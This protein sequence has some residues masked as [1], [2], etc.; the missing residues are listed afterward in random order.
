VN[1]EVH[2]PFCKRL[3]VRFLR[4]THHSCHYILDWKFDEDHC[5]I[6]K[7]YGP[8]NIIRLRRFAIGLLKRKGVFNVTPDLVNRG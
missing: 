2:A 1:R 6:S 8:E 5:R 4:L 3:E 7:G